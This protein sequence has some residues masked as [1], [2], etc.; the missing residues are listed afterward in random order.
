MSSSDRNSIGWCLIERPRAHGVAHVFGVPGD[1]VLRCYDLLVRSSLGLVASYDE[2]GT[3]FTAGI[4]ARL[5]R[6]TA[7]LATQQGH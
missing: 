2:Q 4:Y 1:Y 5:R 6:L 7:E 3:G